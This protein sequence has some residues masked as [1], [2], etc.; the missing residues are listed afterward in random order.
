MWDPCCYEYWNRYNFR[1]SNKQQITASTWMSICAVLQKT[2]PKSPYL[3]LLLFILTS[4]IEKAEELNK[5]IG[6]IVPSIF[7]LRMK[8]K[9]SRYLDET[10][11]KDFF[12]FGSCMVNIVHSYKSK[13]SILRKEGKELL[14]IRGRKFLSSFLKLKFESLLR[15]DLFFMIMIH[16]Y[17]EISN[18][19]NFMNILEHLVL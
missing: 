6:K 7:Y 2:T 10:M 12:S 8:K 11:K 3:Y 19:L 4:Q 13:I 15:W 9:H 5:K 17:S 18:K 1:V 16:L 14:Q